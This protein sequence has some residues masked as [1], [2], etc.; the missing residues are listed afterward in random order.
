MMA[1]LLDPVILIDHF[2]GVDAAT[3]FLRAHQGGLFVSVITRAEVLAG[4]A[5][6]QA[7]IARQFLQALPTHGLDTDDANLAAALRYRYRWKLP[8]AFQAAVALNRQLQ[9]VTRNQKDFPPDRHAFVVVP[10]AL[11]ESQG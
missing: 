10:Y 8:D 1:Y 9:L 11:A 2:N 6:E 3:Q 4:F 7:V 5:P